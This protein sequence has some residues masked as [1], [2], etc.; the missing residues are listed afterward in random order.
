[1][2]LDSEAVVGNVFSWCANCFVCMQTAATTRAET[3]E[4]SVSKL[5]ADLVRLASGTSHTYTRTLCH[6]VQVPARLTLCVCVYLSTVY[7]WCLCLCLCDVCVRL[8][9]RVL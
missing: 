2:L 6:R 5:R 1:M 4:R 9:V 8:D 3:A 7:C